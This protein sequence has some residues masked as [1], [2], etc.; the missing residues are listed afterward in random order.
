MKSSFLFYYFATNIL[1]RLLLMAWLTFVILH[2]LPKDSNGRKQWE[3]ALWR[4]GLNASS[5]SMLCSEHFKPEDLDR[6]GQTVRMTD[7]VIHSVFSFPLDGV[8]LSLL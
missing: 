7:G 1:V 2:R 3:V 8:C 5:S 6:T 4:D